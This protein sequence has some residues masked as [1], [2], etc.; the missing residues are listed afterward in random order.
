MP[1]S[2][3]S[4]PHRPWWRSLLYPLGW[5][6][7]SGAALHRWWHRQGLGERYQTRPTLV[8]VGNLS[9]GGTGKTPHVA[10]LYPH[11]A[12]AVPTALVSRGYGRQQRGVQV[13]TPTAAAT[14]VGDEPLLLQQLLPEALV[15]V[16]ERRSAGIKRALVERPELGAI[17][18]D[19]ALQH[20]AIQPDLA[21]LLTTFDAPFFEDA[22]LPVGRLREFRQGYQRADV[23]IVTK[24]PS[25]LS[26]AQRVAY[27]RAIRPLPQQL[28]LF[29]HYQ[30]GR[31]YSLLPELKAPSW[32]LWKCSSIAV[33]TALADNVYLRSFVEAH[34]REATFIT[35]S[36]HYLYT[37]EDI[38]TIAQRVQSPLIWI[39]EKDAVKWQPFL[40]LVRSLK[41]M[42]VVLPIQVVL[43]PKDE[44]QLLQRLR[45][46]LHHKKHPPTAC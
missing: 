15:V 30:Y 35:Y 40:P 7:G 42:V 22:I 11:L 45:Q 16:A 29:S 37:E 12:A 34:T 19:D 4:S 21:I 36:D 10:Y 23:I 8:V 28:L 38:K 2:S 44:A 17:L 33:V 13:V 25:D 41:L 18:L 14:A 5:L 6:Y 31:P 3:R 20:W 24:C 43:A 26:E 9:V 39:T 46:A 27:A 1:S 32:A